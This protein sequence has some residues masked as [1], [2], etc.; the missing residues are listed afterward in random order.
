MKKYKMAAHLLNIVSDILD[1]AGYIT[2]IWN[3]VFSW[4]EEALNPIHKRIMLL[5]ARQ[6]GKST[7]VAGKALHQAKH[8]K[9]S[10]ILIVSPSEKQSKETMEKVAEYISC[11]P[12]LSAA[13]LPGNSAF[14]KK[15]ENGSRI[16]ALPGTEKSVRGY[17]KPDLII[18]D[19]AARV[20]DETYKAMRPMLT[21]APNAV[22]ILLSTPWNMTGFFH[23]EWTKNPI[24]KK[25]F[26]VPRFELINEQIVERIPEADFKKEMARQ[27][28]DA[29]YSP[30]HTIEFLYEELMSLG[31]IWFKREYGCEFLEGMETMFTMDMIEDSYDDTIKMARTEKPDSEHDDM[32]SDA[33]H[34]VNYLEE[35]F[36]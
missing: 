26:V 21:G 4:Q 30:R 28:I 12:E 1:P 5:C 3:K 24:W 34:S 10:L 36:A 8:Y 14:E 22:L 27:G 7:I 33:V 9:G 19:E 25:I 32:F 29:F 15:F 35:L 16:I 6:S 2:R 18:I 20:P 11:D 31:P 23:K 17:S 13:Q